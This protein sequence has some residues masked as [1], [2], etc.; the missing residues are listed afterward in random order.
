MKH[1]EVFVISL[2]LF[3]TIIAWIAL[4]LYH[5]INTQKLTID[6][7]QAEPIKV[8]LNPEIFKAL[9]TKH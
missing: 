2:M 1:K 3:F 9:E 5:I 6:T 4:D 8:S 7:Q